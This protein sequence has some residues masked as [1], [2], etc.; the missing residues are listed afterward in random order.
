ML[1][2]HDLPPQD[3][4]KNLGVSVLSLLPKQEIWMDFSSIMSSSLMPAA[5][6]TSISL[7]TGGLCQWRQR[8]RFIR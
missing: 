3:V 8:D 2:A 1:P 6:C 4:A 5:A 7:R